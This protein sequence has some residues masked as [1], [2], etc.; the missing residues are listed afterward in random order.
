MINGH[1][2]NLNQY[3]GNIVADF[4][5]NI[6]YGGISTMLAK[7]LAEQIHKVC[8][9]PDPDAESVKIKIAAHHRL[10]KENV[11]VCNGSTEAFYLVA[12]YFRN[13]L[14]T[15]VIPS[16]AEY[17]DACA[18]HNHTLHYLNNHELKS[19]TRFNS[20]AVWL[21]NPNNPDGKVFDTNTI[22]SLCVSNPKTVFIVDEA[23]AELCENFESCVSLLNILPNLVVIRSLTKTFAIPGIRLGYILTNKILQEGF[24]TCK[25]PWSVNTLAIEA[26]SFILD[27]YDILLPDTK[28]LLIQAKKLRLK[29]S[30]IE[31]LQLVESNCNYV[32]VK[33]KTGKSADLKAFLI[34]EYGILIRDASNFRG[35]DST[36]FRVAVQ[37][38]KWNDMLIEGILNWFEKGL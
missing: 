3:K 4:S 22:H 28:E 17:E 26:G 20:S 27:N 24:V 13:Q 1:G 2:N 5:S 8:N 35:L 25:M 19:T 31:K 7:H 23:Y 34:Q 10:E 11:I 15:I 9:Y 36:Y 18:A 12:H 6:V 37:Q 30:K 38:E 16:F 33:L 21:G 29:L 14:T 32:L